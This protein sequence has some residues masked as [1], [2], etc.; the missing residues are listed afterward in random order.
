MSFV[1]GEGEAR[2]FA[3]FG[4]DVSFFLVFSSLFF[5]EIDWARSVLSSGFMILPTLKLMI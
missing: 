4:V 2:V 3:M 5:V 1:G